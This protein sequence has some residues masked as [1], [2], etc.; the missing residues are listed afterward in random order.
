MLCCIKINYNI[1]NLLLV[2]YCHIINILL[3][4]QYY[5]SITILLLLVVAVLV[6]L[7][8]VLYFNFKSPHVRTFNQKFCALNIKHVIRSVSIY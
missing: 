5:F 6:L 4:L 1:L 2:I 3:L 7:L 8:V